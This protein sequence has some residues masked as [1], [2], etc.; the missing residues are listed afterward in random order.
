ME[1]SFQLLVIRE[2]AIIEWVASQRAAS[3]SKMTTNEVE[4][5][6]VVANNG[7]Q[8]LQYYNGTSLVLRA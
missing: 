1:I 2:G 3:S 7:M 6:D 4:F 8:D 5:I